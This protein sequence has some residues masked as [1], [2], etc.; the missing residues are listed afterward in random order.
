MLKKNFPNRKKEK[1]E[2]AVERQEA[3]DK[4]TPQQ[5]LALLDTKLGTGVGAK[6]QRERLTAAEPT[7]EKTDKPARKQ[8][9]R[10]GRAA[11]EK[12]AASAGGRRPRGRPKTTA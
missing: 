8:G 9:G 12:S 6:R 2:E 5:K 3:Y 10:K 4:L 11:K 1:R 7:V